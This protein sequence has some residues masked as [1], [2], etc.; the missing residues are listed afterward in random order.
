MTLPPDP[1]SLLQAL[2]RAQLQ[3]YTW[4]NCCQAN[5][6]P[7]DA[8]KYA[9][10][11]DESSRL[12]MPLWYEGEQLP[13]SLRRSP[14]KRGRK[15]TV[16]HIESDPGDEVGGDIDQRNQRNFHFEGENRYDGSVQHLSL[17]FRRHQDLPHLLQR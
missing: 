1:D 4:R 11:W 3:V 17:H 7:V 12:L 13:P 14:K 6:E 2:R 10:R 9:W 16:E 15:R 5:I 8:E